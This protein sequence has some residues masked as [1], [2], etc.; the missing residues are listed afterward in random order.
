MKSQ[1]EL[2]ASIKS[3][4]E[5]AFTDHGIDLRNN[6]IKDYVEAMAQE[7]AASLIE[8][9][10][11]QFS[12]SDLIAVIGVLDESELPEAIKPRPV[13]NEGLN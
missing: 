1:R 9:H 8:D 10:F 4:K 11:S 12:L 3:L 7:K 6:A 5:C 13:R 2:R